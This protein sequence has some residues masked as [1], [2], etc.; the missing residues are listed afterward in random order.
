METIIILTVVNLAALAA[1]I[2][3]IVSDNKKRK[4]A[5]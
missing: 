4:L 1:T 3:I 5:H 2:S